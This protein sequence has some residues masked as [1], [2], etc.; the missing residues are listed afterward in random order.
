MTEIAAQFTDKKCYRVWTNMTSRFRAG[1]KIVWLTDKE[2][3]LNNIKHPKKYFELVVEDNV[4][5]KY[6]K[7]FDAVV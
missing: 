2:I 7:Y 3:L 1:G 6:G 4:E 5:E